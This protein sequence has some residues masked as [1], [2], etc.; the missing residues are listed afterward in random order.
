MRRDFS[1]NTVK[2][3]NNYGNLLLLMLSRYNN[4]DDEGR[5]KRQSA[6]VLSCFLVDVSNI[7]STGENKNEAKVTYYCAG[8]C[9]CRRAGRVWKY[10]KWLWARYAVWRGVDTKAI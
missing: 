8:H 5:L 7:K 10:I 4:K 3:K 2:N 6:F 9:I 1:K